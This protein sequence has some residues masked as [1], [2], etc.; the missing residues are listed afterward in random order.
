MGHE[1][2]RARVLAEIAAEEAEE[3]ANAGD[4]GGMPDE[5]EKV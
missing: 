5:E 1:A 2:L 3:A 4:T